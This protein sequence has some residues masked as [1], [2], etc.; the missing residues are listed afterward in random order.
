MNVCNSSV[1]PDCP[2]N[3]IRK[4]TSPKTGIPTIDFESS[5]GLF[6]NGGRG[7]VI[8]RAGSNRGGLTGLTDV[9]ADLQEAPAS[10]DGEPAQHQSQLV[11][12]KLTKELTHNNPSR[13][14]CGIGI[15][16]IGEM[17]LPSGP[18]LLPLP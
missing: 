17:R 16:E 15:P 9:I 7:L 11:I 3:V 13:T 14:A 12:R 6:L 4:M 5:G 10:E 1:R 2:G 8:N 18:L